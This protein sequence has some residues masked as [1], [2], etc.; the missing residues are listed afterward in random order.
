MLVGMINGDLLKASRKEKG[1]SQTA[2]AKRVGVAQQLIGQLER[3][4]VRSSKAVYRIAKVLDVAVTD[5]DPEIPSQADGAPIVPVVGYVGAGA[6]M[7]FYALADSPEEFVPM[8][9]GGTEDT[10]AVMVRGS[11]LGS[12]FENWL[13]YYDQKHEPPGPALLRQLCVVEL[14]DGRVLVKRLRKGSEPGLYNLESQTEGL[15]E[16]V[17]VIWAAK[18]K[19]MTPR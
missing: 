19:H 8:P 10:V 13:V 5:L 14:E 9:P 3:G 16:D 6:E 2:L 17:P 7:H 15:I 1:F 11:S 18:V 4:E 12:F